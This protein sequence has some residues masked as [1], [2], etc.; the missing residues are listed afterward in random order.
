M[1]F[2]ENLL[3]ELVAPLGTWAAAIATALSAVA[4]GLFVGRLESVRSPKGTTVEEHGSLEVDSR[5]SEV[6]EILQRQ[7]LAEVSAGISNGLIR[8]GQ[9]VI[10]GVLATSV[11]QTNLSTASVTILGVLV[12]LSTLIHQHYRPDLRALNAKHRVMQLRALI[13]RAEDQI[14]EIKT[15]KA[16]APSLYDIRQFVSET[17]ARVEALELEEVKVAVLSAGTAQPY[18]GA[19]ASQAKRRSP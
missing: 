2:G 1:S 5:L 7:E 8:F 13:R 18:G 11:A 3:A 12:L 19:D 15:T 6:R 14:F 10:G 9:Y 17:L 4:S 16:G